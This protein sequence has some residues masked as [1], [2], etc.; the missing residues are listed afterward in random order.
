VDGK[1]QGEGETM[2]EKKCDHPLEHR[3]AIGGGIDQYDRYPYAV[4]CVLCGE[5]V[6]EGMVYIKD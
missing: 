4:V 1:K 5:K 2:T 6:F 3:Q